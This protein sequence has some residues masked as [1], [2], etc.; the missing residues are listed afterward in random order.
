MRARLKRAATAFLTR[1]MPLLGPETAPPAPARAG[2]LAALG[3]GSD[4]DYARRR[5]QQR[6]ETIQRLAGCSPANSS[7]EALAGYVGEA[8]LRFFRTMEWIELSVAQLA[9]PRPR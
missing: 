4:P 1:L 3:L 2:I 8:A 5:A 6:D 7:P 9:R